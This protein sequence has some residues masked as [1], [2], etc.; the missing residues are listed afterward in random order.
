MRREVR[1]RLPPCRKTTNRSEE[2]VE[3]RQRAEEV[4]R[5]QKEY[6]DKREKAKDTTISV[7]DRVLLTQV[8]N[9]SR[10]SNDPDPYTVIEQHGTQF[11]LQSDVQRC[12][13]IKEVQTSPRH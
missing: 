10:P 6:K 1:T 9:K 12:T 4:Q 13:E 3:A 5:K 7:G 11:I 8:K 2:E